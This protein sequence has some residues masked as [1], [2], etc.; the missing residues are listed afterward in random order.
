[1]K[2][3][4]FFP[5]PS[6]LPEKIGFM[7]ADLVVL[8]CSSCSALRSF[9]SH[10]VVPGCRASDREGRWLVRPAILDRGGSGP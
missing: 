2:D 4:P 8:G 5:Y 3:R 7:I 9:R 1:M 6:E 10:A